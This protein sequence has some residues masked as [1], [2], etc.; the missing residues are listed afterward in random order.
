MKKWTTQDECWTFCR[1]D[2]TIHIKFWIGGCRLFAPEILNCGSSVDAYLI[3]LTVEGY[4]KCVLLGRSVRRGFCWF[5]VVLRPSK[6]LGSYQDGYR[7]VTVRTH[8]NFIVLLHWDTKPLA[9]WPV[10]PLSQVVLTLSQPV[11]IMPSARLGSGKYQFQSHWFDSIRVRNCE[12]Q[13]RTSELWIPR[14][15]RMGGRRS[16]HVATPTGQGLWE[17]YRNAVL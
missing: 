12:V 8:G 1:V 5:V 15:S 13:I 16:T 10:I 4:I 6:D 11:L 9:P 17:V 3:T 14:S 2:C 7:L